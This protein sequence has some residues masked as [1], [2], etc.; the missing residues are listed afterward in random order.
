MITAKGLMAVTA[1]VTLLGLAGCS[2]PAESGTHQRKVETEAQGVPEGLPD[3]C[4]PP[5]VVNLQDAIDSVEFP[6]ALPSHEFA[7]LPNLQE[8]CLDPSGRVILRFPSPRPAEQPLRTDGL[9]I[10]EGWW[11]GGDPVADYDRRLSAYPELVGM[12]LYDIKGVPALGDPAH[13]GEDG[14]DRAYLTLVLGRGIYLELTGEGNGVEI[15]LIGGESV[16]D[17]MA[18]A[19]TLEIITH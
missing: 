19:E 18:I 12:D 16:E 13:N 2:S 1:T 7:S 3:E 14:L 6:L 8:V 11:Y 17:L 15:E 5:N 10:T 4:P 9:L